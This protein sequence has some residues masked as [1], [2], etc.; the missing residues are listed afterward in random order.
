MARA[1]QP[2]GVPAEQLGEHDKRE[3]HSLRNNNER[4]Y[5]VAVN[6]GQLASWLVGGCVIA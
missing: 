5:I 6:H 1:I 3:S 4:L 2:S